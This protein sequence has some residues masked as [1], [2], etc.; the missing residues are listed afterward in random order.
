MRSVSTGTRRRAD[1]EAAAA[2]GRQQPPGP[3][4]SRSDGR[5]QEVNDPPQRS[6][7]AGAIARPEFGVYGFG[8]CWRHPA[9]GPRSLISTG[10]IRPRR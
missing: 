2:T 10:P 3:N 8:T 6:R 7:Y 5:N 9:P 1:N 4:G